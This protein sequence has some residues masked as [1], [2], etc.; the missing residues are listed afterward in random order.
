MS[1]SPTLT[2]R[3]RRTAGWTRP[4]AP[5][6]AAGRAQ[7]V[8]VVGQLLAG[9]GNLAFVAV[10]ARILPSRGF[11]ELAAFVALLTALHLP[12][13]GLAAA[14]A[15]RG[16][17]RGRLA[18]QALGGGVAVGALL[19]VAA[20]P[21]AGALGLPAGYVLAL[22]G[23]AP[24]AGLLGL[25]RG[26]AYGARDER[27]VVSSLLAEPAARLG[28]GIGLAVTVGPLGAAWGAVAGGWLALAVLGRPAPAHRYREDHAR[29]ASTAA[30]VAFVALA[31]LQHQDLVV[32]QRL[33]TPAAAA[34]VAALSALGGLVAFATA[35]LPMVLLPRAQAGEPHALGVALAA[36]AAVAFGAVAAASLAGEAMVR[37]VVGPDYVMVTSLLPAY[38]GAMGALGVARVL[39]AHRVARG[40]GRRVAWWVGCV[41]AGHV[42]GL[43]AFARTPG[44]VVAVSAVSLTSALGG[45][46][47]P[48]AW[49]HQPGHRWLSA[50]LRAFAAAPDAV[51]L[52][53]LTG[54]AVLI[55]LATDRSL[56]IDEAVSLQ[57]AQMPLGE[58]LANLRATDVHPPLH[59]LVLWVSVRVLGTAEWAVRLPS[60]LFGAALIPALHGAAL[61]LFDRR[62]ARVAALLAVPAPFLVW[63]SQEARMY[64]LFMLLGVLGV[65]AQAAAL[66][67]GRPRAFVAWGLASGALLWTQWFAVLPLLV[68]HAAAALQVLQRRREE[69]ARRLLLGWLGAAGI[70][71]LV[72]APLAPFVL[73]QLAAYSERGA[74]LA[75]PASAGADASTVATGLSPYALIANA[76]WAVGGYHSDDVMLRLGALWPLALLAAL[77]LLGRRLAWSS[78]FLVAVAAVP[79]GAL[80]AIAHTKRDLFE[81]RYFVLAVPLALI[82]V[83]RATTT[84]AR[85]RTALVALAGCLLVV[86]GIALVDQQLNGTNPRLYDFRGAVDEI[87]DTA[88]PGDTL[89]FA[90]DYLDGVLG[91]YAPDLEATALGRLPDD[92]G[93]GQVYVLVVDRFLTPTGAGQ[94]GDL[95]AQLEEQRGAPERMEAPNI[96]IWRFA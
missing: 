8:V 60:V 79:A 95:L 34:Q 52:A 69:G 65:W 23:A 76:L 36:A 43:A 62:T 78:R 82:L 84:L 64:A 45:L 37:M 46:A 5:L 80:F 53:A 15:L 54:A 71:G 19:A 7:A 38:L 12:G 25:R 91:Y 35:T 92:A 96:V 51:W 50:R 29:S 22:A 39:A 27:A 77:L 32:A 81:L 11:A 1:T 26:M 57:Q 30:A 10:A 88:R 16:Q 73:E 74:G 41:V 67:T 44:Q 47:W 48:A 94:V 49:D 42:V 2:V 61:Q 17:R 9:L 31:L 56:W 68:Q 85:G 59:H 90:P 24:A 13:A 21:V 72:V 40:E 20:G 55:R 75:L 28:L 58:M 14:G 66:A 86:S 4:A 89:V 6:V 3:P 63:Y 87:D 93:E 33:L 70:S 18:R 83:A